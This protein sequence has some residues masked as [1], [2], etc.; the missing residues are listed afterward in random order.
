[1][2]KIKSFWPILLITSFVIAFFWKFFFRG[3][4]PIPADIVVGMYLPW[5]D[6]KWGYVV[7]V[8]VKNSI[9]SDVVSQIL[10]W[11]KLGIDL[12]KSGVWP[13]WNPYSFSGTP[14]L[15]N[16]QSALFNPFNLFS[17]V[18]PFEYSWSL[19]IVCQPLLSAVFTYVFLKNR[20]LSNFA[21]LVGA[22]VFAFS[23]FSLV[24]L[25]YHT[26]S[27]VALW[28][29][30]L[31]FFT[32]K[33]VSTKKFRWVFFGA[34]SLAFAIFGGHLQ[35][36]FYLFLILFSYTIFLLRE[37]KQSF[38]FIDKPFFL[39]FLFVCLGI[40][41]SA[42][43]ILPT[44][45]LLIN[46][47]RR[48]E[49]YVSLTNFGLFPLQNILT[50]FAPDFFG[51]PATGN[52]W[53]EWFYPELAG[54]VGV[55]PL[56]LA[57]IAFVWRRDGFT[58]FFKLILGCSLLLALP[59]GKFVYWLKIPWLSSSYASRI[60]VLI[61]FSLAVLAALGAELVYIS[62]EKIELKKLL[63]YSWLLAIAIFTYPLMTFLLLKQEKGSS[64]YMEVINQFLTRSF[65]SLRNLV[66]PLLL[67]AS[68]SI[69]LFLMIASLKYFKKKHFNY[70][71]QVLAFVGLLLIFF[72]LARFGLKYNPFV[73]ANFLFP[74]TPIIDFLKNQPQPFRFERER[75]ELMP[76]NM[77][78]PYQLESASG[79]DP[80]YSRRYGQFLMALKRG[81]VL[82]S[83]TRFGEIDNY[84]SR[85]FDL[86]NIK[87]VLA[88]KR[89]P[90]GRFTPEGEP[91]YKFEIDKLKQIFSDGS[92]VVFEN[93]EALSRAFLVQDYEVID[94]EQKI[95]DRLLE[96]NFPLSEKIILEEKVESELGTDKKETKIEFI[97]SQPG[98]VKLNA[99]A[100]D[101]SLLFISNSFDP[102]WQA[103]I[104]GQ[105]T[106]IYRANFTFQAV[107]FPQGEHQVRFIYCPLSFKI[108]LYLSLSTLIL[109]F[110][111]G[112]I[113]YKLR[114]EWW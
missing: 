59:T 27:Y 72:D 101:R 98:E 95:I 2:S 46:S 91:I 56:L 21:S 111:G 23:G 80:L 104:D 77:W 32:D 13:L 45:D 79:Y 43:Q 74:T 93:E 52:Y 103:Y 69:F 61:D 73:S 85:L 106:K 24:W 105:K 37:K 17:F 3:L 70:F 50:F 96:P 55:L 15:A 8:P 11:R 112:V 26:L 47:I 7:G 97:H 16:F 108:G 48:Y 87:Y 30:L 62:K 76:A 53:G 107:V 88:I 75:G 12:F 18:L 94:D 42:I 109:I 102:G 113:V 29:P 5:L 67:L 86:A 39:I 9:L 40:F 83:L 20:R 19:A 58:N 90:L 10:I 100:A 65:V 99:K 66:L 35:T 60:L 81:S 36:L 82:A 1:M 6:F 44:L 84:S 22:T 49:N 14:L 4:L 63:F 51:N 34:F 64:A 114:K 78:I 28:I 41:L 25:E 92:V 54:Y 57:V 89:D 68:A 31:L 110:G 33:T 38:F 71:R